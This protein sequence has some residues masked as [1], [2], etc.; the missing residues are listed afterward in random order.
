MLRGAAEGTG[1]AQSGKKEAQRD[2]IALCSSPKGCGEVEVGLLSQVTAI[3][4][5]VM[6][7]SCA[8]QVQV[9]Y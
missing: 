9:G 4:W 3:A 8:G 1:M 7:L 5:E 6:A 2:P